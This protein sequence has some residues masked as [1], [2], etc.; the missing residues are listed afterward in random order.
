MKVKEKGSDIPLIKAGIHHAVCYAVVDIGSVYNPTYKTSRRKVIVTWE[1]PNERIT[2]ERDGQSVDMPRVTSKTYTASL[3]SKGYLRPDLESWRGRPFT[4]DELSGFEMFKL[5]GA[6]CQ[7]NIIHENGYA[8]V[9]AV[10]PKGSDQQ[11]KTP[12]N[13]TL[14]YSID[15]DREEIPEH[16]PEWLQNKIK[17]SPEY[18]ALSVPEPPAEQ[19]GGVQIP[20]D[21]IPF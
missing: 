3:S 8:N 19:N 17:E 13:P 18:K 7:L 14:S 12:E 1:F 10:V 9:S 4:D 6:N 2:V 5:L 15:D 21:E 20:E 16:M 11:N